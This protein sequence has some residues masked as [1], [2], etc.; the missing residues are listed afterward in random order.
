VASLTLQQIQGIY[1]GKFEQ[2]SD[3]GGT[4]APIIAF[5][6]PENSGSQTVMKAKVMQGVPL[7]KALKEQLCP[8]S[9]CL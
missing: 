3:V 6:R 5:Q 1:S 4:K 8:K 7:R 9:S 2:W